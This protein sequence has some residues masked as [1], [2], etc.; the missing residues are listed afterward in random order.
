VLLLLLLL[1]NAL[2]NCHTACYCFLLLRAGI[3]VVEDIDRSREPLPLPA[4]YFITPSPASV[5]RLL[6]DFASKPLYP[7]AHVY[8]SNRAGPDVIDRIKR[9]KVP[10][11]LCLAAYKGWLHGSRGRPGGGVITVFLCPTSL[12]SES[13]LIDPCGVRAC[14]FLS[15]KFL[16]F[17]LQTY[18]IPQPQHIVFIVF[19]LHLL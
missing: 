17:I 16:F 7:A 3:S 4:V 11:C 9:C 12:L 19:H 10:G 13:S 1:L 5:A 18:D 15:P 6:A 14:I 8:F 2:R